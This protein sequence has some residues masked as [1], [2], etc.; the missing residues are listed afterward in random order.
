V[1]KGDLSIWPQASDD[2]KRVVRLRGGGAMS[3][4]LE[5]LNDEDGYTALAELKRR[6]F[7]MRASHWWE[8]KR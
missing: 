8:V 7:V 4:A 6:E 5:Y 1:R 2:R 3:D